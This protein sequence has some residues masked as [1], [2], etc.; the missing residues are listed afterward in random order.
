MFIKLRNRFLGWLMKTRFYNWLLKEIIPY[1]RF[2]TYYPYPSNTLFPKW[3]VL[4]HIGYALLKPGHIILTVDEKKLTTR[5]ISRFTGDE[6]FSHA[7]FCVSKDKCFEI[8]EM[9]HTD[10]T[11]STW[12]D[13]CYEATRVVILACDAFDEAYITEMCKLT[14]GFVDTPYDNM[15]KMGVEALSCA[16]L[17]YMYDFEH[18]MDINLEPVLGQ[19]PYISPMG[20]FKGKNLQVI[21]DSDERR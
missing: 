13:V 14:P 2:T 18:R 6:G 15:F 4:H 17:C 21:W 9:T 19:D 1:I 8:A 10:F 5:L 12:S 20:L 3:G 16:E 7:A 11:K